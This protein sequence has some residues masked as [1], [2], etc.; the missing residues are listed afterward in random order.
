[1]I[2]RSKS[3]IEHNLDKL[4][5]RRSLYGEPVWLKSEIDRWIESLPKYA[6]RK[7]NA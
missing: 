7:T 6:R 4:P 3:W 1:M 5:D 2:A